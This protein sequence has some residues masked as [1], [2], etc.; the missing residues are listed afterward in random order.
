MSAL[1]A[2]A[3]SN[4]SRNLQE[5]QRSAIC[6]RVLLHDLSKEVRLLGREH[7]AHS[8]GQEGADAEQTAIISLISAVTTS[9]LDYVNMRKLSADAE[10]IAV[11]S[12]S[13]PS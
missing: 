9:I 3:T 10:K 13:A 11:C 8:R 2:T 6:E 7:A 5:C 4:I 1:P 12:A